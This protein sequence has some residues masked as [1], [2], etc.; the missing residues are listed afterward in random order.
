VST[1]SDPQRG[2]QQPDDG[3]RAAAPDGGVATP[4]PESAS[5]AGDQQP[6]QGQ[7]PTTEQPGEYGQPGQ[8]NPYAQPGQYNPYAQPGQ[9]GGQPG[10]YGQPAYGQPGQYGPPGHYGT[11]P[12][13][14]QPPPYAQQ[15]PYGQQGQ[16]GQYG[17]APGSQGYNPYGGEPAGLETGARGPATRPGIMVLSV[18]LL[19]LSAV[20]FLVTGAVVLAL[21]LDLSAL[22]PELGL[23]EQMEQAGVTAE[24][25]VSFLRFLAVIILVLALLYVLFAVL[26]F[27]GRNWARIVLTIMTVGFTLMMLASATASASGGDVVGL[28]LLG[29]IVAASVIGTVILF[30]PAPNTYFRRARP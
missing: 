21:P 19:I 13:Y 1:P 3:S 11:P 8:Y 9:Y 20:P 4:E 28:G 27:L 30:L 17:G 29:L 22:P 15:D 18:V 16:Y 5:S 2:G 24:A 12:P 26:S 23:E 6:Q 7:Q 14:G 25:V 10:Q